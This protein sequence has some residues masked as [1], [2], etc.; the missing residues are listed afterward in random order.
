MLLQMQQYVAVIWLNKSTLQEKRNSS[1]SAME[2]RLSCSNPPKESYS[3]PH[4]KAS[5][6]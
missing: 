1:V 3:N 6:H 5:I 2:L 4:F